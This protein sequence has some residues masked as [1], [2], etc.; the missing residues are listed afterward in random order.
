MDTDVG[1]DTEPEALRQAEVEAGLAWARAVREKLHDA[2]VNVVEVRDFASQPPIAEV[3]LDDAGAEAIVAMATGLSSPM[4]LSS[5]SDDDLSFRAFHI[6]WSG[7]WVTVAGFLSS[8][9][10]DEHLED[11]APEDDEHSEAYDTRRRELAQI[12]S[13][14]VDELEAEDLP[15]NHKD[16][17]AVAEAIMER[18]SVGIDDPHERGILS[19]GALMQAVELLRRLMDSHREK[20]FTEADTYARQILSEVNIARNAK[21]G[22]IREVAYRQMKR[23]DPKCATRAEVSSISAALE[24]LVRAQR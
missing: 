8:A 1:L 19:I 23:R 5:A 16:K 12:L 9:A 2:G 18:A 4:V 20:F 13:D 6:A 24:D 21:V 14:V 11:D 10:S 15:E 7:E 22:D 17:W 3:G